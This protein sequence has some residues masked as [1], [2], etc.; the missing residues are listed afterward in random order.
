MGI[1]RGDGSPTTGGAVYSQAELDAAV[2]AALASETA[3]G[4]SEVA[5]EAAQTAAEL[6]ET[7]AE[8]AETNAE[9][10][11]TAAELAETNAET[12]QT[13]AELAETNAE[14]AE[15]NA[16]ASATAAASS[17]STVAAVPRHN[18]LANGAFKVWQRGGTFTAVASGNYTA[19]R[20]WF[21]ITATSAVFTAQ[22]SSEVPS[23][24]SGYSLH[25]D[26]TTAD[27]S[28][29]AGDICYLSQ[30]IEGPNVEHLR[31]GTSGAKAVSL[32]FWV[33][34]PKTGTHSGALINSA[35]NRC[36]TFEY[37]V[38]AADTWEYITVENIAGDTS[39]TWL[40]TPGTVGLELRFGLMVG[41]TFA[42]TAGS[43]GTTNAVGTTS[44]ANVLDNTANNL[45][46]KDIQLEEGATANPLEVRNWT[47]ELAR[48][49]RYYTK[50][51]QYNAAPGV[52]TATGAQALTGMRAANSQYLSPTT[53]PVTMCPGGS[54]TLWGTTGTS[55]ELSG[56]DSAALTI[57][58]IAF[59][60]RGMRAVTVTGTFVLHD[61][62]QFHWAVDAE[63]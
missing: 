16:A 12:A 14:T 26:C 51:Y 41:S 48:C 40:T 32:S 20:W 8:T 25:I 57:S 18:L 6:A 15:T 35:Q 17:A 10:A 62:Y 5:A 53:F 30:R 61:R 21:G 9:T 52:S 49:Q 60:D 22:Q 42:Q 2:A 59:N 63:L 54:A 7:N 37:T 55:N 33:R 3:A 43:W 56:V 47:E 46:F 36:Y 19:D 38:A 39:G 50:S 34:S 13:A 23:T 27:A 29:A 1:F 4:I 58:S 45:Y 31:F 24:S 44:Q 28:V 11:Q